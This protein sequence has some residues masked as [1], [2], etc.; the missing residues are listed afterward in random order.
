MEFREKL[1]ARN[2]R[3]IAE[4]KHHWWKGGITPINAAIRTT[5][6]YLRWKKQVI[7]RDGYTCQQ[8]KV[9]STPKKFVLMHVDH[10]EP[11]SYLLKKFG[12]S[13]VNDARRCAQLFDVANGRVLCVDCHKQT[14]TYLNKALTYSN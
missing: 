2:H 9:S 5:V 13:T 11:L 8:C 10:I 14:D 1:S 3:L 7:E 12:I 4:G 6:R